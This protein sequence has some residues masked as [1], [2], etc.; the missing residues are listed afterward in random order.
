MGMYIWC[1]NRTITQLNNSQSNATF[2]QLYDY[3][4]NA[5]IYCTQTTGNHTFAALKA[6]VSCVRYGQLWT[7]GSIKP[8]K[9]PH[10]VP[11]HHC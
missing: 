8:V 1:T 7:K 4:I 2:L 5:L 3:N 6:E 11:C 10:L 9:L